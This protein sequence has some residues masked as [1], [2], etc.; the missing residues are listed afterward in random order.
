MGHLIFIGWFHRKTLAHCN[1]VDGYGLCEVT[2]AYL[3][4]ANR[5]DWTRYGKLGSEMVEGG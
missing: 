3:H 5:E 2:Q 4:S 1:T